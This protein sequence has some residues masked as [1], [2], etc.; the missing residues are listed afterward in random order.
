MNCDFCQ[1]T[2]CIHIAFGETL[3]CGHCGGTGKVRNT[4]TQ[5]AAIKAL[6]KTVTRAKGP[7]DPFQDGDVVRWESRG[8]R[9]YMYA[10][11]RAGGR[12]WFTGGAN[13]YGHGPSCTYEQLTK[14]LSRADIHQVHVSS[15]WSSL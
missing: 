6:R 7:R 15:T 4:A 10:A 12:W 8:A 2:G 11:L 14:I 3:A 5:A 1:G 9:L 13:F